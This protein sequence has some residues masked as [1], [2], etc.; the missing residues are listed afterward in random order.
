MIRTFSASTES[1]GHFGFIAI[2]VDAK[3][4]NGVTTKQRHKVGL[5]ADRRHRATF[6]TRE[7]ALAA[8]EKSAT[9]RNALI[10]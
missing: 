5:S 6:T 1:A 3:T 7:E 9:A 8:A 10:K 4:V 2:L